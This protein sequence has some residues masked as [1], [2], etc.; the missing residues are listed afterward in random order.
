MGSFFL[1]RTMKLDRNSFRIHLTISTSK[2][3]VEVTAHLF[4]QLKK[5]FILKALVGADN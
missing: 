5:Y 4:Q 1:S 2:E 3:S